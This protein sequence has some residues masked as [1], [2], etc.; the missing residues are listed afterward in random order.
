[1]LHQSL[2]QRVALQ[3]VPVPYD[4]ESFLSSCDANIDLVWVGNK[5]QVFLLPALCWLP[6]DLR[7]GAGAYSWQDHIFPFTSLTLGDGADG[8]PVDALPLQALVDLGH[9]G[10]VGAQDGDAVRPDGAI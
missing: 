10:A 9:L 2:P 7:P 4:A 8:H 5:A 6:I 1:M 3:E